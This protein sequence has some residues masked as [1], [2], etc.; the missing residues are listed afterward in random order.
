MRTLTRY[1]L[2]GHF[3]P[4]F[5]ALLILIFLL[6]TNFLLR[7]VDRLLGKGLS[8]SVILEFLF[9]NTAWIV[10][11]AAPMA[12]LI[13]TL[14]TFGRLA[15]DNEITALSSTGV[16]YFRMLWPAVAFSILV[17]VPLMYFN[18][19]ILPGMNHR[20]KELSRDI[21]RKRPDISIEPGY[22]VD[23][24]PDYNLIVGGKKGRE[25]QDVRIFSKK[26]KP[27]QTFI[28]SNKGTFLTMDDAILLKLFDGEIHELDSENKENY[29][30]IIF[31]EH[32]IKV[33]A[34]DMELKRS[35][36]K[37]K[38]DREMSVEMM[39]EKITFYQ[40]K[41]Q[42]TEQRIVKHFKGTGLEV[43]PPDNYESA[44]I[45]LTNLQN[46]I[47]HKSD[48]SVKEQ[49]SQT[50]RYRNLSQRVKG[51]YSLIQA[52]RKSINR[53]SV[54]IHKKFSIP[55]ACIVFVLIGA[56]LGMITRKKGFI[57]A[58]TFSF[59]FFL[60]YWMFLI[61]GEEFADRLL[62]SPIA[63]M[64]GPNAL[65]GLVGLLLVLKA[66]RRNSRLIPLLNRKKM[67]VTSK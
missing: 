14:M 55:V 58:I 60:L 22:F 38:S 48:L 26:S 19:A 28:Q 46:E 61:A 52:Y 63:A 50:R 35:E 40:K 23:D 56:P 18:N 20:A 31:E 49:R 41:V 67:R 10:A 25:F 1:I 21:Y 64:W 51:D 17:A 5:Y 39:Q 9:L 16:S 37:P 33:P 12:V 2:K 24:L 27:T 32:H 34:E 45:L 57:T 36:S 3:L 11:L 30:R 8:F 54:E 53:Y 29:R 13:A 66:T 44:K 47:K 7:A 42:K 43:E 6:F 4:F 65:L 15:E 59:G 62:L